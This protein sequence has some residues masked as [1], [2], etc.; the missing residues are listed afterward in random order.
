MTRWTRKRLT[1]TVAATAAMVVCL[2]VAGAP[3]SSAAPA[4]RAGAQPWMNTHLSPQQRARLLLRQMTLAEKVDLMTS[5]SGP[6]AFF[7]EAIPRLGIPA[8]KMAD[9]GSGVAPRGWTLPDTGSKATALPAEIALGATWSTAQTRA[10]AAVVADEVRATGQNVLLGPDADV[11]RQPWFGRIAEGP[12]EDPVLNAKLMTAYVRAVQRREV[13]ATLK[14]YTGYNQETNRNIGQ[15]SVI[16]E[17]TLHE[18]YALA[19]EAVIKRAKP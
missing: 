6:Y 19:F 14:H 11:A 13:I 12:G 17:R 2:G 9:A 1:Q 16:D 4:G 18:V 5:E 10:F 3:A 7:N 8:L 15:N